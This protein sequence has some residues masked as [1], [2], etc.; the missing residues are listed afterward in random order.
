[1]ATKRMIARDKQLQRK[2]KDQVKREALKSLVKSHDTDPKERMKAMFALQK[3]P[4]DESPIRLM[5]RCQSCGRTHAVYRKFH[6]CRMCIRDFFSRGYLPG[7][8]KS[9]W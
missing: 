4:R 7:V 3:R 5:R 8:V 6:L 2:S 1:M 9:S